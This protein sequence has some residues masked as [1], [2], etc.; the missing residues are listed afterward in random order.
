MWRPGSLASV[1]D[2]DDSSRREPCLTPSLPAAAGRW[3]AATVPRST[4]GPESPAAEEGDEE[5]I[6]VTASRRWG[7]RVRPAARTLPERQL[8]ANAKQ[9]AA[10][11]T[12]L[13]VIRP[14]GADS[15]S[16]PQFL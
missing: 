8:A 10:N 6:V 13:R 16:V 12:P 4:E 11:K 14:T 9:W 15:N 3:T 5:T 2:D 1:A 7:C